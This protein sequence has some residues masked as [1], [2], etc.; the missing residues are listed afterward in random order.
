LQRGFVQSNGVFKPGQISCYSLFTHQKWR[1]FLTQIRR[2]FKGTINWKTP[3][4]NI[5]LKGASPGELGL[6][7]DP[8]VREERVGPQ[9]L[10]IPGRW[11]TP[12]NPSLNKSLI[13]KIV[14][15]FGIQREKI[16]QALARLQASQYVH[17]L[18]L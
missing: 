2:I 15:Q 6:G 16:P 3:R 7:P 10:L 13:F 1:P 17:T 11:S 12:S 4:S 18:S 8:G 5:D 14:Q 9:Q